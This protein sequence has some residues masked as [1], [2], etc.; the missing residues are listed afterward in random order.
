MQRCIS[1]LDLS[2]YQGLVQFNHEPD[3]TDATFAFESK[4]CC[5][6]TG[7]ALIN[8]EIPIIGS[9]DRLMFQIPGMQRSYNHLSEVDLWNLTRQRN[10]AFE[11][12]GFAN[13]DIGHPVI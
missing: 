1:K 11:R 12:S 13:L 5:G 4:Q 3:I 10:N 6:L 7:F 9:S 2:I 8:L